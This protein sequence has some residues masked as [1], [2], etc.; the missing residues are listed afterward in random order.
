[1]AWVSEPPPA[2]VM[3]LTQSQRAF[4]ADVEKHQKLDDLR[5]QGRLNEAV[6]R[7]AFVLAAC[8]FVQFTPA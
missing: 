8:G 5:T 2:D 6:W 3:D 4:F 1:M 7:V